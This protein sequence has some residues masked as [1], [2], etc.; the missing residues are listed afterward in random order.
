MIY[1]LDANYLRSPELATRMNAEPQAKFV[2]PDVAML[3]LC[4]GPEW[5]STVRQSL[6]TVS[7]CPDR[8]L[9]SIDIRDAWAYELW[10][11]RPITEEILPKEFQTFIRSVLKDVAAGTSNN[12]IATI[13]STIVPAQSEIC[14]N[15]LNDAKNQYSLEGR[16]NIIKEALG[17]ELLRSLK[18]RL[19]SDTERLKL[20]LRFSTDLLHTHLEKEGWCK[21]KVRVFIRTK[22]L[23][24]RCNILHVRH[25]MEW[26]I[27]NGLNSMPPRK[28]TNDVL[29]QDYVIIA[30]YFDAILSK[31]KKV[32][33]ADKDLRTILQLDG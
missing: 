9:M 31:E 20:I 16:T 24:L 23:I 14:A 28:M 33:R 32:I 15:E 11:K 4:K 30:S 10:Y 22:P 6:A 7:K 21:N 29:D 5:Q 2:I 13:A 12:G 8:I 18:N 17:R 26:A 3:E 1:V 25:A 27:N 19:P